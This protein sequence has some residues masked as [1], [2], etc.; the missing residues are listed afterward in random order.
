VQYVRIYAD[1]Q[2]DSHFEDVSPTMVAEHYA[3]AQWLISQPLPV[4]ELRFRRVAE[5]F[6]DEPHLAPRRQLIVSLAGESEVEVS[7]GETRRFG[8]GSVIL[9][10]DVAGKGHRT[11]RIGDTVRETLFISLPE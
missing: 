5:E 3:G 10:E 2:G 11:R 4:D 9:V 8:P 1:E 7:D 6:P